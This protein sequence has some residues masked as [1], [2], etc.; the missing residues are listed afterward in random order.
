MIIRSRKNILRLP[1][2]ALTVVLLATTSCG[3]ASMQPTVSAEQAKQ[4]T[5]SMV[6]AAAAAV[7][8]PGYR[9]TEITEPDEPCTDASDKETGQVRVG[10]TFWVDGP[11]RSR[12][13]LYYDS[14]K[15][16]WSDNGWKI[17]NDNRPG[18][19]FANA[20]HDG[21]LMSLQGAVLGSE[22]GRLNIGAS[23]PCVWPSG[24]PDPKS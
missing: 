17:E 9:L 21:Y 19:L 16:W 8:P 13:D 18:D 6:H 4:A 14:I 10:V 7:F 3:G 22:T 24:T 5:L 23:S 1:I 15:K 12:N 2:A 20:Q 11:D